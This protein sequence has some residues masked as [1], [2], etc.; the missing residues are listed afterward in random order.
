MKL[1]IFFPLQE[2]VSKGE[3]PWSIQKP[4]KIIKYQ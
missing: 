3:D 1:S 2:V 4:S